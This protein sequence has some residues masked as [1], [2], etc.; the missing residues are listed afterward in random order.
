MQNLLAALGSWRC[1]LPRLAFDTIV[2]TFLR[3]GGTV[4]V[5]GCDQIGGERTDVEP[6][7]PMG[8]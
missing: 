4:T 1:I 5:L 6:I 3:H 2:G 8:F 7:A